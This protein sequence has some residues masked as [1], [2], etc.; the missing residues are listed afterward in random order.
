[1]DANH[2]QNK[3]ASAT[4]G[5][6]TMDA[7]K[8]LSPRHS[9][10]VIRDIVARGRGDRPVRLADILYGQIMQ[11]IVAGN[12]VQGDKLPSENEICE[13]FSV[14]RPVVREAFQRLRA[15][16]L[17][18]S[19]KG[20]GTYLNTRPPDN[21]VIVAP[22]S[23]LAG[24]MRTFEV[25]IAIE[26]ECARLA[27]TRRTSQNLAAM[28][29]AFERQ[30]EAFDRGEDGQA[31][32]FAFHMAI[33]EGAQNISF[34]PVFDAIA[35]QISDFMRTT[36]SLTRIG[37]GERRRRV[38][39]EHEQVLEA[40]R[41]YRADNAALFMQYHLVQARLRLTDLRRD[42]KRAGPGL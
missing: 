26:P 29:A 4:S 5:G 9:D 20:S 13:A 19:R 36:L 12:Y 42:T 23:S 35:D 8:S 14:S 24:L 2:T 16:G 18:Y 30:R 27:A 25:R 41:V 3:R 21:L 33:A 7:E 40:I 28:E 11:Q 37:S 34:R 1:M 31:E 38:L 32:D 22:P 15:D 6:L 39:E 10:P 17:V